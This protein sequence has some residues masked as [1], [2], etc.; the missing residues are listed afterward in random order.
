[1]SR[2]GQSFTIFAMVLAAIA[3]HSAER[4]NH[5]GRIL[6]PVPVITNSILFNTTNA[7]AVVSAMQIFPRD[8]AWNEDISRRPLLPNSDAMIDYIITSLASNRRTPRAFYEM[9]FVLVPDSQPPVPIAFDTDLDSYG[10]ESDPSPY[11]FAANTPVETWPRANTNLTLA[12]WQQTDDG[13]DRHAVIV[14]PGSNIVWETWRTV[15]TTTGPTN[16][17]AASGA[18]FNMSNNTLRPLGW[19]SADAAGLSMFGG[20]VRFDECQRG[21][22]EHALRLVV[23]VTRHEY[24]YPA[25]HRA[26]AVPASTTNAPA[27]GQRL[28]L[29]SSFSIPT[30]WTV[31]ETAVARALKKYGAIVADNGNFFSV[32]V[33]PDLRFPANAFSNFQQMSLTN[34]EVIQSTVTT[35]GPRSPGAPTVN[36][37]EDQAIAL[38]NSASLSAVVTYTN[39][40]PLAYAWQLYSGPTNVTLSGTN[41]TNTVVSFSAPGTY[42]FL[43]SAENGLH[44]PAYDAVVV[45][46]IPAIR[47]NIARSGSSVSL[48]WSGG[49]VP[50]RIE[51]AT[52]LTQ[53]NWSNVLTTNGTNVTL[54]LNTNISIYRM[55]SP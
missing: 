10:D 38:G 23:A 5:E 18:R 36:A 52:S 53:T 49:T 54:P 33:A 31:F 9:N 1:M 17:H 50:F 21:M 13:S 40:L 32:S 25:T 15:Y 2:V 39:A 37:G 20:L 43:F 11:P 12:Q 28:R 16:W 44:T 8:N 27:M 7:D 19:T 45:T 51:R 35:N 4:I 34:F 41:Q 48:N 14:M 3:S 46:V 6:G 55:V 22:V 26:G 29:K 47:M 42:T 24:I 30:N